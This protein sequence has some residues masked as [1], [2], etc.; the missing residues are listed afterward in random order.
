MKDREDRVL[1]E[2]TDYQQEQGISFS[3]DPSSDSGFRSGF[4]IFH[5]ILC[6]LQ[7]ADINAF[8]A[9]LTIIYFYRSDVYV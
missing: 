4:N 7:E 2:D 6:P 1:K 8:E 5:R 3:P 9:V